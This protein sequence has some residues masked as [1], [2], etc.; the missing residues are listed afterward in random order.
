M[1]FARACLSAILLP[2]TL[3]AAGL[4]GAADAD[5]LSNLQ[6]QVHA[7]GFE[8]V[9]PLSDGIMPGNLYSVI[10]D[11][12]NL[13]TPETVCDSVFATPNAEPKNVDLAGIE[14]NDTNDLKAGLSVMPD[15]F[16]QVGSASAELGAAGITKGRLSFSDPQ[17]T[18]LPSVVL[19]DGSKRQV[20]KPCADELGTYF[21]PTTGKPTRD[22]YLVVRT[23]SVDALN[24]TV[25]VKRDKSAGLKLTL[26]QLF[27]FDF[28]YKPVSDTVATLTFKSESGS[29]RVIGINRVKL[30]VF[31]PDSIVGV[32]K[33]IGASLDALAVS[34]SP[35]AIMLPALRSR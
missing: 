24:Y 1:V 35:Q 32:S 34:A 23:L 20:R 25:E 22:V 15:L 7:A 10:Q 4:C 2:A 30:T 19:P 17:I 31:K 27:K 26:Q 8:P 11:A 14:A 29:R 33:T 18:S 28:G 21:D 12:A 6:Q 16:K 3:T 5:V 13:A 9:Y